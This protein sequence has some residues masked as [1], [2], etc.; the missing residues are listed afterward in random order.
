MNIVDRFLTD[1][2]MTQQA[3]AQRMG[4]APPTIHRMRV[5]G[6]TPTLDISMKFAHVYLEHNENASLQWVLE[7]LMNAAG[8]RGPG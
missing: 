4:V 8:E 1:T 7:E 3:L 2:G 6:H 5:K